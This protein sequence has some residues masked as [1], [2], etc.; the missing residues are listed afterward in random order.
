[1]KKL[2]ILSPHFPPTN[3]PD[4]QRIRLSLPYLRDNGWEPTVIAIDPESIEGGVRDD[5]LEKTYPGDI[6]VIRVKGVSSGLTRWAGVGNLW[7]R[8]GKAFTRAAETLLDS[9]RFDLAFF[10]TTQFSAFTLGPKW[11]SKYGL[12]YVLDYQDPWINDYYKLTGTPPPGGRI[13]F[14]LSQWTAKRHEPEIVTRAAKIIAVSN[15]Y[16]ITLSKRYP[17]V[18]ASEVE[19]IPFGASQSDFDSLSGYLPKRPIIDFGDGLIHHVYAG[20]C[21][22]DMSIAM[23]ALFMAFKRYLESGA[24]DA[25]RMRFHFIGTDY[26][27]PPMGRDWAAP[28]ANACGVGS[29]VHEHRQRVPYFDALYYLKNA[30]AL[31]AVGSNDPTYSASKFFPYVL[32]RRPMILVFHED[33]PVLRFAND[34]SFGTRFSFGDA[35]SIEPLTHRI[36]EEWFTQGRHK[37]VTDF[38]VTKFEPY[39]ALHL[40]KRLAELFCR[41]ASTA[42]PQRAS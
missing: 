39:T 5:W 18:N 41:A 28:I 6:R 38:N 2:L 31:I 20:R 17:S 37:V 3:A 7:W 14:A 16:G 1:M 21:G 26:S 36:A 40:T 35:L 24:A 12:P 25:Q 11:L 10:S 27:P 9:E 32:A 29:F 8:C 19:T 30:D 23:T 33:S 13:K 4:M 42:S 34:V 22:P 15:A